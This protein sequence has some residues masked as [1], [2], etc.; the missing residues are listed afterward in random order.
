MKGYLNNPE[1]TKE[2]FSDDG[3]FRSGD[4][5]LFDEDG[6]L[7]I[8]DRL[9]Y[10]IITGGENVYSREVEEVLCSRPE[11]Q[12]CAVIGL[13]DK[14]WGERVTAFI[15]SRPAVEAW[16]KDYPK[17]SALIKAYKEEIARVRAGN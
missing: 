14:E 8:V 6:Y 4:I 9:K 10:M 16:T 3:W 15:I 17:G 2:A 7:Y 11:V 5:G 12:E 13:P 1:G